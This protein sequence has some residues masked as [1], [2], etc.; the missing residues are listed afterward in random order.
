MLSCAPRRA[1][2]KSQRPLLLQICNGRWL[3]R[4]HPLMLSAVRQRMRTRRRGGARRRVWRRAHA[5]T[6]T[7][8]AGMRAHTHTH[9]PESPRTRTIRSSASRSSTS[10]PPI[11][12]QTPSSSTPSS[13]PGRLLLASRSWGLPS[14]SFCSPPSRRRLRLDPSPPS[15]DPSL[16]SRPSAPPNPSSSIC[17]RC[18]CQCV[19]FA[20]EGRVASQRM[21]GPISIE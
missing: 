10:S 9:A 20:P 5:R 19:R 18:Q 15:S 6:R 17:A 21:L 12:P 7:H 3:A 11:A 1:K 16:S 13:A 2:T 14:F 4:G 8:N